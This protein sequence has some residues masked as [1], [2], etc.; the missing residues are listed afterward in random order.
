MDRQIPLRRARIAAGLTQSQLAQ[1]VGI[2]QASLSEIERMACRPSAD[3]AER[4]AK[5]LGPDLTEMH[6]LYPLRF[7]SE[8]EGSQTPPI[9]GDQK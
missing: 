4:L 9:S 7:M 5:V 2:T 3:L 8:E 1:M 6:I